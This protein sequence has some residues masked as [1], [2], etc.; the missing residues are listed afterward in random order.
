MCVGLAGEDNRRWRKPSEVERP[1]GV[2]TLKIIDAAPAGCAGWTDIRVC[3]RAAIRS[4]R[5]PSESSQLRGGFRSATPQ[6]I[7]SYRLQL[8]C[9]CNFHIITIRLSLSFG[10]RSRNEK[11]KKAKI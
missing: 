2:H 8:A 6:R 11:I 1:P 5:L 3:A 7:A 4:G 10:L 9:N